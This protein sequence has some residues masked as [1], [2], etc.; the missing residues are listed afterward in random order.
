[1]G[2]AHR[3]RPA[4]RV[5]RVATYVA[6][7]V[8]VLAVT[9]PPH[10]SLIR[11]CSPRVLR[12]V[13]FDVFDEWANVAIERRAPWVNGIGPRHV[14]PNAPRECEYCFTRTAEVEIEAMQKHFDYFFY[15]VR[16]R[17]PTSGAYARTG[18][19]LLTS[20]VCTSARAV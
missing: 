17:R 13:G 16:E 19:A 12:S 11:L 9:A 18:A 10:P 7:T 14:H 3:V 2:M 6:P 15:P 4:A 8:A 5:S 20:R 1:M